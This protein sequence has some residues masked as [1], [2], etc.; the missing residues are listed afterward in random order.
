M[1]TLFLTLFLAAPFLLNAQYSRP[2]RI[3]G[4]RQVD[5]FAAIGIF[6][7]YMADKPEAVMPPLQFGA[8]WMLSGHL[9]LGAFGG[10]STSRSKEKVLFDSVRGR[11]YNTTFF[12]GLENGFHY[13]RI[14]NWDLYG[15]FCLLYQYTLVSSDNPEF[16]KI[17]GHT[18]IQARSGKMALTAYIGSRFALSEHSSVFFELGYGI[19]LLKVGVGYML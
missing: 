18:G 15:G 8:R 19:S 3:F 4:A 13:T 16:E 2:A 10:Y 9:S 6:P 12:L 1:K 11:W 7:T 5:M 17:M 14:D